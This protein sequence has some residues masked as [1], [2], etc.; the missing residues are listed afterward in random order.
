MS[1]G[2]E[3]SRPRIL[4]LRA[5]TFAGVWV[6]EDEVL[7][8]YPLLTGQ[9]MCLNNA[10]ARTPIGLIRVVDRERVLAFADSELPS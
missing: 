7:A 5:H 9:H 1:A 8:E 4:G 6:T 2:L 3:E 10:A